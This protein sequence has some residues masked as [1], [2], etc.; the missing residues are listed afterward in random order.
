MSILMIILVVVIFFLASG[1]IMLKKLVY[2]CPPETVLVFSGGSNGYRFITEGKRALALP[3]VERVESL[4]LRSTSVS[5]EMLNVYMKG[6]VSVNIEAVSTIRVSD[7]PEYIRNAIERFLGGDPREILR[8]ATETLEGHTR[9][10]LATVSKEEVDSQ[11]RE[12]GE[13][14]LQESAEDFQ[15]L[16]LC[17]DDFKIQS[18]SVP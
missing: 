10:V 15:K 16:G 14:I 1:T 7:D 8:V 13:R 12:V 11:R 17:A 5:L 3:I 18:V 6:G 9:S 4:S 2:V